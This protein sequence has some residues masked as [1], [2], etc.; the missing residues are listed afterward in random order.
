VALEAERRLMRTVVCRVRDNK[1]GLSDRLPQG[2]AKKWLQDGTARDGMMA[3]LATAVVAR[4]KGVRG[5]AILDGRVAHAILLE[6]FTEL[7]A[8]TLVE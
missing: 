3:E 6:L 7:G 1:G 5:V 4:Q 8:G 2:R